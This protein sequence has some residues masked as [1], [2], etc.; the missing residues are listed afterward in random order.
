MY[1]L[2]SLFSSHILSSTFL[3]TPYLQRSFFSSY[4]YFFPLNLQSFIIILFS[5]PVFYIPHQSLSPTH[6]LLLLLLLLPNYL[7]Q[8]STNRPPLL[9]TLYL[10]LF[11]RLTS[12]SF[13]LPFLTLQPIFSSFRFLPNYAPLP[14]G[15]SPLYPYV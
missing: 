7:P 2:L 13:F 11:P 3:I 1:Y 4:F 14:L 6:F 15:T 5:S 9:L 12:W 10:S 8:S